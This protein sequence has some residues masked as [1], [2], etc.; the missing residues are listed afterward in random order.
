MRY[1]SYKALYKQNFTIPVRFLDNFNI[2]VGKVAVFFV[3]MVVNSLFIG[4]LALGGKTLLFIPRP[5]IAFA[6]TALQMLVLMRVPTAGKPLIL[7]I[8]YVLYFMFFVNKVTRSFKPI[9]LKK[10]VIESWKASFRS[11]TATENEIFYNEVPLIGQVEKFDGLSLQT[12]GATKI[13]FH[14]FSKKITVKIG[15]YEKLRSQTV[16][17]KPLRE[18]TLEVGRGSV[19]VLKRKGQSEVQYIPITEMEE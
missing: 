2:D 5:L 10:K 9:K 13:K 4:I 18:T 7:W 12:H 16:S 14:P 6:L 3:L 15:D 8:F 11:V 19:K 17:L 1:Q